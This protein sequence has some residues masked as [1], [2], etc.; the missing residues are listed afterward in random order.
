MKKAF[1]LLFCCLTTISQAQFSL[2]HSFAGPAT[3]GSAPHGSLLKNGTYLYGMT[4]DGGANS[5]GTIFR[6]GLDGSGYILLHS[7]STSTTNGENPYGSLITDGTNLYGMTYFGGANDVGTIFRIGLDGSGF[8]LLHSFSSLTTNGEH[9]YGSLISDGTNLYGMTQY[10]GTTGEG[11]IFKIGID[12]SGFTLLHSFNNMHYPYGSLLLNGTYLYG[13][14]I[15][16]G[17][18]GDGTIFRIGTDGSGFTLLHSFDS[19]SSTNGDYPWGSLI[20]DGTYLY[21]M[22]YFGGQYFSGT[23]FRLGLDGSGFILLHNFAGPA[24]DGDLP[25]DS[26]VRFGTYLYGMTSSGGTNNLGTIF[27]VKIDGSDFTLLHIFSFSTTDGRNPEG[28]LII[29]GTYLYGMTRYGG[30]ND[31]GTIFR[32]GDAALPVELSSFTVE[33]KMQGVLCNWTTESEIENLG[34][35]LERK[36]EGTNWQE[37]ASYKTDDGLLGQG[38]T[39][40]YTN[41]EYLDELVQPNTTYEYRLADVDHNQIVTYHSTRIVTVGN[42][43]HSSLIEEFTVLPAYPNPFNPNTTIRYGIPVDAIASG[44]KQSHTNIAIYDITGKLITTLFNEEQTPGWHS[45]V[46]N[47]TNHFGEQAP[48]GLY[49]SR[50]TS[51]SK[52]K[53]TKLMLLK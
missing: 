36:T 37:I 23:V 25:F 40:S 9:P 30:T 3:D 17:A 20:T 21:G 14:T 1:F 53:T 26:L 45:I 7:F 39:P 12:G 49:F 38:T 52:I 18:N 13:M 29:D 31:V 15:Y 50:I 46:W 24:I 6:I 11:T 4:R 51:G 34:F 33:N 22:T 35:M 2:L 27:R 47:G 43:I 10:G 19:T 32:L 16:G 42:T 44:A 28:S 41:Y 5:E 48:A 8:I